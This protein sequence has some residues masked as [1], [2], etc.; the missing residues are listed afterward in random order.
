MEIKILTMWYNEEFLAPF[1]LSHYDYVDKI[2]VLLDSDT[3][4][5][6]EEILKQ[7]RKVEIEMITFPD[8]MD[9][10]IKADHINRAAKQ[11]K[12]DWLY[13]LDTDE[14]IFPSGFEN[15]RKFLYRIHDSANVVM[16]KM[17]QVYRHAKDS[18]LDINKK[19]VITQRRCGDPNREVGINAAYCKPIILKAP[20]E[21]DLLYG[22]HKIIGDNYKLAEEFFDGA[23]WAM[24]DKCFAIDRRI[25]GRKERQSQHNL[26]TGMTY[27]QHNI[28]EESLLQEIK[29]HENDPILF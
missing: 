22:N 18:D 19:P 10:Q 6:T 15:P 4:D 24:A 13:V 8:M 27:H 29:D 14:F 25:K 12:T 16:A 7:S 5:K 2:H 26:E 21:F 28:T 11:I 17:W 1:F 9:D 23:H 3:N 20:I